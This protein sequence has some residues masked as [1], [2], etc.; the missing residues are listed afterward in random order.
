MYTFKKQPTTQESLC[1]S[2][3]HESSVG[4]G[5]SFW[6]AFTAFSAPRKLRACGADRA[7]EPFSSWRFWDWVGTSRMEKK[8][9]LVGELG[10]TRSC[11]LSLSI[12]ISVM[13]G[14]GITTQRC[15]R[16]EF[17]TT[18]NPTGNWHCSSRSK[19]FHQRLRIVL[20]C[21]SRTSNFKPRISLFQLV[22]PNQSKQSFLT[23]SLTGR[24]RTPPFAS[25]RF[26]SPASESGV[27]WAPGK[28]CA[29]WAPGMPCASWVPW[30]KGLV[31]A[32]K[33]AR[34][35]RRAHSP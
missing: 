19:N 35:T 31:R 26:S 20:A 10:W 32:K 29:S 7:L 30:P 18:K 21:F 3:A 27:S 28:P 2:L 23:F 11:S 8:Q 33:I 24:K 6:L 16:D 14:P 12:A 25:S 34:K 1:L 9:R 5:M 17:Y 13:L 22:Q 15:C 4:L